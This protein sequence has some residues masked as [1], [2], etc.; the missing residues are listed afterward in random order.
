MVFKT[1]GIKTVKG[2]FD[3]ICAAVNIKRIWAK[4]ED[5]N[6]N[7]DGVIPFFITKSGMVTIFELLYLVK[8][9][10]RLVISN[11]KKKEKNELSDNLLAAG[12]FIE[13][14]RG[15]KRPFARPFSFLSLRCPQDI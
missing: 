10:Y 2:E 7:P 14:H 13:L 9:K 4:T 3:L 15:D 11:T 6:G 1:G 5:K 12:R 8:L